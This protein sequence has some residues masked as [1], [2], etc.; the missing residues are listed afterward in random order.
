[1]D[2]CRR[3]LLETGA[4][5]RIVVCDLASTAAIE[6]SA[7]EVLLWG[8]PVALVNNAGIVERAPLEALT[9][10]SYHHQM[11][12]NLLAPLWLTR[13][14]LPA[15]KAAGRGNVV[16]VGSISATLG[17]AQQCVYNASKWALTGFTRSLAEELSDTGLMTVVVHPGA[18]DTAMLR[19]S[20]YPPRMSADDVAR[21]LAFY[22]LDATPAHNGSVIEMF[23]V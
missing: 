4:K 16:N 22:S 2:L 7:E 23:G 9:L 11:N 13:C 6:Q 8:P 15:M 3:T 14:L 12:V 5:A 1:L 18:V 17:S 19:G 20:R 10:E 21:T